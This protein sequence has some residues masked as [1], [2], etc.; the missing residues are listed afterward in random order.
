[1][2]GDG[3]PCALEVY[4]EGRKIG[5]FLSVGEHYGIL[6]MRDKGAAQ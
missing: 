5:G 1:M 6:P 4:F 3:P 2:V